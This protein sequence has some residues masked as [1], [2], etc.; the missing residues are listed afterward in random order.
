MVIS[1]LAA[2]RPDWFAEHKL[3][4][5]S[6][7]TKFLDAVPV[8]RDCVPLPSIKGFYEDKEEKQFETVVKMAILHPV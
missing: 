1:T 8:V 2:Q 6:D 4:L 5:L 7:Q 3:E